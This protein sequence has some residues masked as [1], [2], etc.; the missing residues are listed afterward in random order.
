MAITEGAADTSDL[1]LE[2]EHVVIESSQ[3]LKHFKKNNC[4]GEKW[5]LKEAQEIPGNEFPKSCVVLVCNDNKICL[6][7]PTKLPN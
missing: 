1:L 4:V 7:E 3:F 2:T 6:L 5:Y